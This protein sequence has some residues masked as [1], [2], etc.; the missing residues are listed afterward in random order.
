MSYNENNEPLFFEGGHRGVILLHAYTGSPNDVRSLGRYLNS[1]GYSVCL[2][3][4]AGHATEQPENILA[5]GT[6]DWQQDVSDSIAFM[7]AKGIQQLAIFG[8]SL[9]GVYATKSLA[10]YSDVF[11]GGGAFCSPLTPTTKNNIFPV[12]LNYAETLIKKHSQTELEVRRRMENVNYQ[13]TKQLKDINELQ[14][15]VE[16]CISE[17]QAPYFFAQ[18]ELDQLVDPN[19]IKETMQLFTSTTIELHYYPKSGH[20]VTVGPEK[21]QFQEDVLTFVNSLDWTRSE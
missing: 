7:Q 16:G 19:A 20:V 18:G 5:K 13:L 6:I 21:N 3:T 1:K 9:G 8:L 4:F 11:I 2:P 14:K 17:I 15:H 12:F 10:N